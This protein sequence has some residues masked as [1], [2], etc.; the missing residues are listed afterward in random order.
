L[1]PELDGSDLQKMGYA[2]GPALGRILA[3]LRAARLDGE[4]D[5]RAAEGSWIRARF[6]PPGGE[7]VS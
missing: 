5:D 7:P 2:P 1:R 6:K 4:V 3:A